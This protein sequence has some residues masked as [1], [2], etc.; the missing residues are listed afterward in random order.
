MTPGKSV[1]ATLGCLAFLLAGVV[2]PL[3]ALDPTSAVDSSRVWVGAAIRAPAPQQCTIRFEHGSVGISEGVTFAVL[4]VLLE[5]AGCGIGLKAPLEHMPLGDTD[6]PGDYSLSRDTI[7]INDRDGKQSFGIRIVDDDIPEPDEK[8]LVFFGDLPAGLLAADPD[9]MR[10]A[11]HDNDSPEPGQVQNLRA[12]AGDS[13]V[14]VEWDPPIHG[15]PT[16]SYEYR[17]WEGDDL[18]NDWATVAGGA[19]ARSVTVKGLNNGNEHRFT[20]R[21]RNEHGPGLPDHVSATPQVALSIADETVAEGA[22]TV[23]LTVSLRTSQTQDVT[24]GYATADGTA[25]AGEDYAAV[26]NGSLTIAAGTA[27]GEIT[28]SITDDDADDDDE[29]FTVTLSD[30]VNATI[31]DGAATVTITDNDDPVPGAPENLTA[32]AGDGE[33][34][35]AWEPPSSGSDPS[36]YGYRYKLGVDEFGDSIAVAGGASARSATVTG[37]ANGGGYTFE[38]WARNATGAGPAVSVDA[39]PI[40][41]VSIGDETVGEGDGAVTLTVTLSSGSLQAVVVDFD[42]EDGTATAGSDY[43]AVTNG[44]LT[45]GVG[46]TSGEISITITEDDVD[47]DN[48]TFTVTLSGVSDATIADGTAIV[49]IT[50]NDELG[51]A[52]ENLSAA[53]G[54]GEVTLAWDAPG[55][56]GDPVGYGYR[57]KEGSGEFGDSTDVSGGATARGVTV[58]GL[59][60]GTAYTFEV[61][62]RSAAGPGPAATASATPAPSLSVGDETV[63]EADG[64]VTLTVTLSAI[65]TQ[66]VTVSYATADGT[67]TAGTDYTAV[68]NGSATVTAGDMSV[69]ISIPITDDSDD[70]DDETFTVTLSDAVNATID[71]ATATVTITDNDELG[72][73]PRN[74]SATAGDGE[75]TLAWD[76]PGSGGDPVEYGYRVRAGSDAFGDSTVVSGGAAARSVTVTGLVNGT[77]HT[78]E[79]WAR[80]AAGP[81]PAATDSATPAPSLS[82]GD[83][84][85]GEADGMVTL[86][87]TLSAVSTQDVTVSYATADGTATAGTDYT[88]VTSGS[89][90]ISAGMTSAA[91]S[92]PIA[93]DS[94]DDDDETFTVTLSDATNATIGEATAT[95]TITDDDALPG[96]PQNLS[97]M[98]GDGEVTLEWDPPTTGGAPDGYEYRYKEGTGEF[99]EWTTVT[100]GAAARSVTVASLANGT[101]HTFEVHA[102]NGTG[103]GDA[104]TIAATPLS[105]EI[106]ALSIANAVVL[107]D[108]GTVELTVKLK[109]ASDQQVMVNYATQDGTATAQEDYT[110]TSGTLTFEPGDTARTVTVPINDDT[111]DEENETFA[112]TLADATS[113][114]AIGVPTA[115]VTIMD[116]DAS[117][118]GAPQA[119]DAEAGNTQ[120]ELSWSSPADDGGAAVS[121]YQYR[122]AASSDPYPDNW[123]DVQ[124]GGQ[125]RS[126]RVGQLANTVTYRFQ[127]RA[128]N[129]AGFGEPATVS[130]TPRQPPFVTVSP[131]VLEIVEG[132]AANYSIVLGTEPSGTVTIEMTTDLAGK[133]LEVDPLQVEFTPSNWSNP[134]TIRVEALLDRD[135][136]DEPEI[137]LTHMASGGS[138]SGTEVPS[139]TVEVRDNGFPWVSG[140]DAAAD[141]GDEAVVFEISLN[142]ETTEEVTV[143]Y[144]TFGGTAVGGRDYVETSGTLTFAPGTTQATVAVPLL[145]DPDPEQDETFR[146]ALSDPVNAIV[147]DS[148]LFLTGTIVDTDV[149]EVTVSFA[150]SAHT[151]QEGGRVQ[152]EVQLSGDPL[153]RAV[154]PIS[155]SSGS[156][157]LATDFSVSRTVSF[158]P[159]DTRQ[160]LDFRALHDR[161]DEDDEVVVVELGPNLPKA[162]LPGDPIRTEVTITDDDQRGVEVSESALEVVEGS[163]ANYVVALTSQPVGVATVSIASDLAGTDVTV[164]PSSLSFTADDWWMPQRFVVSAAVDDDAVQDPVVVLHHRAAGADYDGVPVNSV[165]VMVLEADHPTMSVE[166]AEA[167]EG[168]GEIGF[169]VNL[170]RRSSQEVSAKYTTVNGTATGGTDF[171]ATVGTVVFAAGQTSAEIVVRLLDDNADEAAETF[172]LSLSH[173][174]QANPGTLSVSATGTIL[175]DDLPAVSIAPVD[176]VVPE[177]GVVRFRLTRVLASDAELTV[178][179]TVAETGGFLAGA[180]PAFVTFAANFDEATLALPTLDNGRDE[181]DGSVEATIGAG[182]EYVISGSPSA[183]VT[184]ADNDATPTVVI[185]GARVEES[186]GEITLPVTMRGESAYTVTV[187]WATAD[188]TARAGSDYQAA[189]GVVT[190]GPGQTRSMVRITVLDDLVPEEDE[191]FGVSLSNA[192]NAELDGAAATVTIADDDA[193]LARAWLSRFGRT[194]ASQVVE[195]VT[196]RLDGGYQRPSVTNVTGQASSLIQAASLDGVTFADM[197][198]G[199]AYQLG[200]ILGD[201]TVTTWVR[202]VNTRFEGTENGVRLDGS[203][204]TG[205]VGVDYEWGDLLAG[206]AVSHSVGDGA[207]GS[208]S[209]TVESG[210]TSVYPYVRYN[211]TDRVSAWGL[212]GYGG[213]DLGFPGVTGFDESGI[214]M[215]T[216]AVGAR[217]EIVSMQWLHQSFDFA[218]K[219]DVLGVRM[220]NSGSGLSDADA[221]RVRLLVEVSADTTIGAN[222][223]FASKFEVGV[224][225]DGGDAETGMGL[226]VGGGLSYADRARGLKVEATIRGMMAHQA[227]SFSE[228][229]FGGSVAYQ[230]FGPDEGLSVRMGS[231]WGVAESGVQ[232][233]WSPHAAGRWANRDAGPGSR[234]VPGSGAG[235]LSRGRLAAQVHYAF[236]PF[237]D[238]LSMAPYAEFGL[239]T[240]ARLGW[241][242]NVMEALRLSFDVN[243]GQGPEGPGQTAPGHTGRSVTIRGS[244][245][246]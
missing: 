185:S 154:V 46:D 179:V 203:V 238:E 59:A 208:G 230:P 89:A 132:S 19:S 63:G 90:T 141:E 168:D 169:A 34:I 3:Q 192:A 167:A 235:Q 67:A 22:G 109:P 209:S 53:P 243:P 54:D 94:D 216:G 81:G 229:G 102:V 206:L 187:S 76:P 214:S 218:L 151:V 180:A 1:A 239:D 188:I 45:I 49:T 148:R 160:V 95:V 35:L 237:G 30:P 101:E 172:T 227:D 215:I 135:K 62:A 123:S 146:L 155:I 112:V 39:I 75:V 64:M 149:P 245:N 130:A 133:E 143:K 23:T 246:R 131:R 28:I 159:G 161:I 31:G 88:A 11:I 18:L 220:N 20:V 7:T 140:E 223:T 96:A 134:Q 71:N 210:L 42:T 32:T 153:R 213:G 191:T 204:F 85:V 110:T 87:V 139:V 4:F 12:T 68:T 182:D 77:A 128:Q 52:P 92:I 175:D 124:G 57:Y 66:D 231:S 219:T 189:S 226:E 240:S 70:D 86:A 83:E 196:E 221:N 24:V 115:T 178:P 164:S 157:V 176:A 8:F 47:D 80:S 183:R 127:V 144:E 205:L 120:V 224:R 44:S 200:G 38:V 5:P 56:G 125:A 99:G 121:G 194:V 73:P 37:L 65:S 119:L 173:F 84:T 190:F 136:E 58:T 122:Y 43:T 181:M 60:N 199:T 48:E 78:F 27:S 116:N 114:S 36:G 29:T 79:V 156:G 186:A 93:D 236:A 26:T 244:L 17:Y 51:G 82:I 233:M 228:W 118:P 150:H 61:W 170:D 201:G 15:E 108:A 50:D 217:A 107:E 97:A 117:V 232:E 162:F 197:V 195:G 25:T 9:T 98:A 74:L 21:A 69:E 100:G 72:G 126:V 212:A 147:E 177:G 91:I 138:Y 234:V 225:H 113:G 198:D 166:D 241:R 202:G 6:H 10:V 145:D 222:A 165:T 242:F 163:T 211:V 55:S 103:F 106:S 14:T 171:V 184:V 41:S 158:G 111:A 13:E 142:F 40:P 207:F 105:A 174:V 152:L 2:S 104:A 193:G 129:E 16:E 33:V 137:K